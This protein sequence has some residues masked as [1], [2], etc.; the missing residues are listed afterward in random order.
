MIAQL[1]LVFR[2]GLAQK[3]IITLNFPRRM[4][5]FLFIVTQQNIQTE[6]ILYKHFYGYFSRALTKA[7]VF[8]NDFNSQLCCST[9]YL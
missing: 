6:E 3:A 7:V 4:G 8:G 1:H 2:T 5:I 9:L